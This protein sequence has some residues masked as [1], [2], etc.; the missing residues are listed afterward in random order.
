MT[1]P[2][3]RSLISQHGGALRPLTN[4]RS[5]VSRYSAGQIIFFDSCHVAVVHF[6]TCR[7]IIN[8]YYCS[9]VG[10]SENDRSAV[11]VDQIAVWCQFVDDQSY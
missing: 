9:I 1:N 11:R 5:A 8:N 4:N 7:V 6:V 3:V 10:A 2:N